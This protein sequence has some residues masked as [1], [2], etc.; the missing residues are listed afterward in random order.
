MTGL[1]HGETVMLLG[2]ELVNFARERMLGRIVGSDTGV[3][4]RRNPREVREPD[5]AFFSAERLPLG[6]RIVGPASIPPDLVVEVFSPNDRDSDMKDKVRMWLGI[7]VPLVWV[8]EPD[9]CLITVHRTSH[10]PRTLRAGDELDGG[11]VLPGFACG[12]DDIFPSRLLSP[13][14][15]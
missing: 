5:I 15:T 13:P 10:R 12:I 14:P 4:V 8:V 1:E 2:A 7:G 9:P 3:I 11:D 6:T